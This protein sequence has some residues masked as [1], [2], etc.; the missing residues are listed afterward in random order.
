MIK[1]NLNNEKKQVDISNIG[2]FDFTKLKIKAILLVIVLI[3]IPDFFLVPMWEEE[4]NATNE[5]V[6]QKQGQLNKLKRQVSKSQD[7]EKQIRE[8]KA[9]E[10]SL[11]KKLTA[12]KQA[13]SEKR[14]PA[15]ILLYLAKN[16]PD[17]L[18][19][20]ELVV[21]QEKMV[22]KGDALSYASIG[23]FVNSLRSSVFIRDANII[24]TSSI[25]RDQDKRRIETFEVQFG[26]ARFDQ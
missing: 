20:K 15:N 10:E 5:S 11:G 26:I 2:G 12:V 21:D 18:W 17:E 23:N 6:T 25:V 1:I 7:L 8:L 22:I 14:N 13:I 4:R 16:V 3:Y 9:Q 19:I 24:S